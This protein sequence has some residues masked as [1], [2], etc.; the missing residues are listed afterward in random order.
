MDDLA[1]T[2]GMNAKKVT[3]TEIE[4]NRNGI[5]VDRMMT[6]MTALGL[7]VTRVEMTRNGTIANHMMMIMAVPGRTMIGIETAD[8][9]VE[10]TFLPRALYIE[11][12]LQSV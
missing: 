12:T 5:I 2:A 10:R 9:R 11:I 3:V 7:T 8:A 4:M 1:S 6:T